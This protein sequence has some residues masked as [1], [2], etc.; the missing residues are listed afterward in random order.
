LQ[1]TTVAAQKAQILIYR[2][3]AED[4]AGTG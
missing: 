2:V 1:T 3:Q 4:Y